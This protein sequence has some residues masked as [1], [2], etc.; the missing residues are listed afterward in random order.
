MEEE[1][2]AGG[3]DFLSINIYLTQRLQKEILD[4][5]KIQQEEMDV[6][7]ITRLKTRT[8]FGRPDFDTIFDELK[9]AHVG[10][11]K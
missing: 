4:E 6:D 7:P 10:Q 3:D 9:E 1:M 5:Y 8:K 2:E 11:S